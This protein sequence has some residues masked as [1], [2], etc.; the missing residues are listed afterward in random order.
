MRARVRALALFCLISWPVS[1]RGAAI[2]SVNGA[3][4]TASG[5]AL[6]F[7]GTAEAAPD[8][9]SGAYVTWVDTRTPTAYTYLQHLDVNGNPVA[10]WPANGLQINPAG[11]TVTCL[12][13][14][15]QGNHQFCPVVVADGAGGAV[16]VWE[17]LRN[18]GPEQVF[19]QRVNSAGTALWAASGVLVAT[20]PESGHDESG[21]P[22]FASDGGLFVIYYDSAPLSEGG[23]NWRVQKLNAANGAQLFGLQGLV[24]ASTTVQD[25][26]GVGTPIADNAAGVYF[27]EAD[28]RST[29]GTSKAFAY[30]IDTNGNVTWGIVLSSAANDQGV[31]MVTSPDNAGG[32]YA[33]WTDSRAGNGELDIY[34]TRVQS[35]GS[36]AAGW[37]VGLNGGTGIAVDP[38]MKIYSVQMVDVLGGDLITV[39]E[40]LRVPA[41]PKVSAQRM[42][43]GGSAA[44]APNG[45]TVFTPTGGLADI[46][47]VPPVVRVANNNIFYAVGWL[48]A[49]SAG[50]GGVCF[51][52][53]VIGQASNA[54][55]GSVLFGSTGTY[56]GSK[57]GSE[58][59]NN[60]KP[61][62]LNSAPSTGDGTAIF[63]WI[64]GPLGATNVYAQKMSTAGATG[65]SGGGGSTAL[66]PYLAVV[67]S[68]MIIAQWTNVPGNNYIAVL[69]TDSGFASVVSSLTISNTFRSTFTA[70]TPLTTYYFEVKI[71]TESDASYSAALSR[72][73]SAG[74]LSGPAYSL[75]WGAVGSANG[76]FSNPQ[77]LAADSSGN[78]YAAD[79][80]NNRVQKFDNLGNFL[81]AFGS[82]GAGNGQFSSPY[83][84]A[85]DAAGDIYAA[86]SGNF[87]IEKFSSAGAY[88]LQW[89]SN[90]TGNGQF[91]CPSGVAIDSAGDVYV[92]D[93]C[94]NRI[95]K[96]DANGTYLTQWGTAGAANGQLSLPNAVAIDAGGNVYVADYGNNRVDKFDTNGNFLAKW[97]TKGLFQGLFNGP[98]YIAVDGF[99]NVYVTDAG[100]FRV[101]EFDGSG[102]LLADWGSS[103][104]GNGQFTAIQGIVV[105][106]ASNVFVG[107]GANDNI[108]RFGSGSLIPP[109]PPPT[110]VQFTLVSS[111]SLSVA[112]NVVA[113]NSY[114]MVLSSTAD[115]STQISS[116]VGGLNQNTTSYYGLTPATYYF[117]VKIST[118]PDASYSASISTYIAPI[119]PPP[120][121]ANVQFTSVSTYTL[122]VSWSL[123]TGNSYLMALSTAANFAST[124]SSGTGALNQNT[125]TYA[126]SPGT[127]YF[128]V[129]IST[130]ADI[131]YSA[132]ISTVAGSP[133][134]TALMV[135][136]STTSTTNIN[137]FPPTGQITLSFPPG[138]LGPVP[139]TVTATI[140]ATLPAA[141]TGASGTIT[142]LGPAVDISLTDPVPQ[143]SQA[144]GVQMNFAP[145]IG[146][147]P[148][149]IH[150]AWWDPAANVWWPELDSFYNALLGIL[151]AY[152]WHNTLH[153]AVLIQ[154]AP[155]LSAVTVFPNPVNFSDSV[156]GTV[157]FMGLSAG[158][159]IRI[160]DLGG[161]RVI[162][163][164]PGTSAGATVNDGT[165]GTAEWDGRNENGSSVARG[166]Y[167]YVITDQ[168]GHK[169]TGKIGVTR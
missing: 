159:G 23:L 128:K 168:G 94:D 33:V 2:W 97:G 63:S 27:A 82:S 133:P 12:S 92:A 167:L 49:V 151:Q 14:V 19:G 36:A 21:F 148:A 87:R 61:P 44:W 86:D 107:D 116:A 113:G 81:L 125:T 58:S 166:T 59:F 74:G 32:L 120:P 158:A 8:L 147:N 118:N 26:T 78:I 93:Q 69:A 13:D 1:A 91:G 137:L 161:Q 10:G 95:Q 139:D 156:R 70:L 145:P 163:I 115:F 28:R 102:D 50:C 71:S 140:P 77:E 46:I 48:Q 124:V 16:V 53:D 17:D 45:V 18:P 154:A 96:F 100:N 40:D 146:A 83:G 99:G 165:S 20:A 34:G 57:A 88:T 138:A 37:S 29:D 79:R 98:A 110:G 11:Q 117:E 31:Y 106:I 160:Y 39:W 162:S 131:S 109:P 111:N 112:W 67:S 150:L 30:R 104:S 142:P 108:Q 103:G 126:V 38:L 130:N 55:D 66:S 144:V 35:N 90:G 89:G 129:K 56:L 75:Q 122:S 42:S 15:V 73:T 22:V 135:Q 60:Y 24:V 62:A 155:D 149:N 3:T 25:W 54:A 132:A 143:F 101:E 72:K 47:G 114:L 123:V 43:A 121:P 136:T 153:A 64:A 4:V 6:Q 68:D 152:I 134:G 169:Q 105:N 41:S 76:Q 164:P 119:P 51:F 85:V 157:K 141:S 84:V 80:L 52:D 7:S 9:S 5:S 65:G 127:Y